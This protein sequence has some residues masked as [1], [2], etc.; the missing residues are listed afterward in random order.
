MTEA[1]A[2]FIGDPVLH[3][4]TSGIFPTEFKVLILPKP[5]EEKTAGGIIVPDGVK[6][7]EEY[8]TTR[9]TVIAVSPFAFDYIEEKK[10]LSANAQKPKAGDTVLY[11]RYAGTRPKGKDGKEYVLLDDRDIC[12]TIEE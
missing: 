9:G 7:K 11:A 6:E 5:V 2:L 1:T 4:N 8:A 12:A 3:L 10:W